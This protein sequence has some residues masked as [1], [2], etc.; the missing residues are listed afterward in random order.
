MV[1]EM[2]KSPIDY[3]RD[4]MTTGL[5]ALAWISHPFLAGAV[6][7]RYDS[8]EYAGAQLMAAINPL[9]GALYRA[10]GQYAYMNEYARNSQWNGMVYHPGM[11]SHGPYASLGSAATIVSENIK[12]LY[13]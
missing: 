9:Y 4:G 10:G 12:R 3:I 13:R 8:P 2:S 6:P 5:R 1:R 11:T 7:A